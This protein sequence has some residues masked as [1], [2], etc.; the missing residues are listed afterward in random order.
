M[1]FAREFR[2]DGSRQ[3]Y[4]DRQ[5]DPAALETGAYTILSDTWSDYD[6]NSVY[7]DFK[8]DEF[9]ALVEARS[10]EPSIAKTELL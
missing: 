5:L 6:G 1:I 10:F 7:G 2:Y 4:L 3:R 9:G 8:F